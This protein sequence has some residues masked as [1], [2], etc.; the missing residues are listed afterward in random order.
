MGMKH[1]V[2]RKAFEV[3]FDA[4]YK[5]VNKDR[6]KNMLKLLNLAHKATG[7]SF[8]EFFWDNATKM[9]SDP[10]AKWTKVIY[11]AF[12]NLNPNVVKMH[13][14]NLA[15]EA[16][17]TGFKE[18]L[19]NR[20]KYNCNI[21]WIIL[22]DPTSACNLKCTGCWAAEYGYKMQR[23]YEQLD[24]VICQAKELGIHF[25]IMTGGEPLVRKADIVK[26]AEKHNDCAF[27]IFT[28]GT[29]IDEQLC[30]DTVRLGNISYALSVEGFEETNDDRRGDGV[31][32]KVMNALELMK[33]Y[34]LV[35][36][37]SVCYTSKNCE[38]VTSD[39]FIDLL[40]EKGCTMAWFFHYMPV[41]NEASVDLLLSNEQREY[42]V[43]RIREIRAMEG[44]K[45]LFCMD[46]QNDAE[47]VGG[48]IAGGRNYL[49][50]N[51][52]GD[53]EPCVFIHYSDSNINDKTLLECLQSP[54]FMAYHNN[55]PFNGNMFRPCPM[56]ENPEYIKKMVDDT[57]AKSTDFSSP[58]PVDELVAKTIPYAERWKEKADELWDERQEDI[59]RI[60]A[61][62]EAKYG[63][64]PEKK[65]KK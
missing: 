57:N 17:L 46:F 10:E 21:P 38:V 33:S 43:K 5:Y 16:G 11:N 32:Q 59:E 50:I 64:T 55:Q 14:L 36:G 40:V 24:D 19:A 49:H 42:M 3:A 6:E 4:V 47:Y 61:E 2:G 18:V 52:N 63:P 45:P 28:N 41:G 35:Y 9:L 54:L 15:Y 25:F 8:P 51:A 37:V 58:E 7:N 62:R 29:L 13:V 20:E 60:K 31:F 34:G 1:T 23:T 65:K 30:K 53:V 44:G 56:L 12:A 27:H 48:C 26:L 39:E 22:M